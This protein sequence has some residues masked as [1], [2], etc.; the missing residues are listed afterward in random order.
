MSATEL[1][2]AVLQLP[3]EDRRELV[4][5]ASESLDDD[6]RFDP[7]SDL[8]PQDLAILE[9]R[10][11]ELDSGQVQPVDAMEMLA[12]ARARFQESRRS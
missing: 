2:N 7:D 4:R 3:V 12:R 9:R 11:N 8:S 1:L 10:I 5:K 6:E